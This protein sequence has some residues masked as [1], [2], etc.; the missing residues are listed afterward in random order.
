MII[1]SIT[2]E[3]KLIFTQ[4]FYLRAL[5]EFCLSNKTYSMKDLADTYRYYKSW[6][7]DDTEESE[8]E[9]LEFIQLRNQTAKQPITVAQRDLHEY[10]ALLKS[11][12]GGQ[13]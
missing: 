11:S 4:K 1:I 3:A 9:D 2:L 7:G 8:D 5:R 10:T 6:A 13:S 12:A